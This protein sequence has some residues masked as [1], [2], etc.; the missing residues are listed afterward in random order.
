MNF[1]D[2]RMSGV[3][4]SFRVLWQFVSEY[5]PLKPESQVRKLL[6]ENQDF[7]R[8][9]L[10]IYA[11]GKVSFNFKYHVTY[12]SYLQSIVIALVPWYTGT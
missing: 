3:K 11:S 9:S 5:S 1:D 2:R 6:E 8:D 7:I 12:I 4:I 10:S